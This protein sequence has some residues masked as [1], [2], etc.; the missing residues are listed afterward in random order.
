[1][2]PEVSFLL[3]LEVEGLTEEQGRAVEAKCRERGA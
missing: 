1:L 2:V 3:E